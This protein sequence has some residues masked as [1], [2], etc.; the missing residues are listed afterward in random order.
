MKKIVVRSIILLIAAG[1]ISGSEFNTGVEINSYYSDNIFMNSTAVE[2]LA[3][4]FSADFNLTLNNVNL[5]FEG[6][7]LLFAD[8]SDFNSNRIHPGIEILKYL[9]GRNYVY[10]DLGYSV[11]KYRDYSGDQQFLLRRFHLIVP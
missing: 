5:Y 10:L 6:D 8:N 3:M 7:F 1:W 9:K 4:N 2:D 11:L